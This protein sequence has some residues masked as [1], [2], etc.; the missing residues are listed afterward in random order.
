MYLYNGN[1]VSDI[2]IEATNRA[3][4]YGDAFFETML[5]HEGNIPLYGLHFERAAKTFDLLKL[6]APPLFKKETFKALLLNF[7]STT[8]YTTAKVRISFWRNGEGT[9]FPTENSCSYL[10][11]VSPIT[12]KPFELNKEGQTLGIYRGTFKNTDF[13]ANV[14]VSGC[15][16]YILASIWV[17]EQSVDDAILLNHNGRMAECTSSNIFLVFDNNIITPPLSEGG[18]NGVMRRHLL[19]ILPQQ[20]Y[21]I[22]E[23]PIE[24]TDLEK[25]DEIFTTNALG[26]KWVKKIENIEKK[27]QN[28]S[29]SKFTIL[30][31]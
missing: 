16:T 27:Y 17:K 21:T 4:K 11:E 2:S 5:Y 28:N 24:L 14:K 31:T 18:L 25:A 7:L 6:E 9:Y 20:G 23:Q 22:K 29:I 8:T 13:L 12:A 3:F 26:I 19:N 15:L 30:N 1:I 10:V